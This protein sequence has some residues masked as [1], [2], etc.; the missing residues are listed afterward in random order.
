MSFSGEKR[1][2]KQ[3]GTVFYATD[4]VIHLA[5]FI[6]SLCL[7]HCARMSW[8]KEIN[9]MQFLSDH[10]VGEAREAILPSG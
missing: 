6:Y 5:F 10:L 8:M 4:S 7:K 3:T 2:G 1:E 9:D